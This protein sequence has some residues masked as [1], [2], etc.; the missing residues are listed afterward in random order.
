MADRFRPAGPAEDLPPYYQE[1]CD[2]NI[3][4]C[5]RD[6][7]VERNFDVF[8]RQTRNPQSLNFC[9]DFG[10][11]DAYCAF[12]LDASSYDKLL[13]TPR[14]TYLHTRWINIWMPY[15]QK[16]LIRTLARHF[17]FTP[18]LLGTMCSDPVPPRPT[19]LHRKKSSSTLRS[20]LSNKSNQSGS[21]K[22]RAREANEA[23]LDFESSIGMSE[24]MHSTQL[25]MVQDLT[26]Y[27]LVNDVWHWSTVDWG[28]RFVSMGYNSLHNV[29]TRQRDEHPEDADRAQD[30]PHGKRVW[31]WLLLCEDKTVVSVS[32]DPFPFHN[33][34]LCAEDLRTLFTTR[35]N[36]VNVFRQLTKAP[37]P[38]REAAFTQ[39]P[40]RHRIG[41]SEEETVHRTTD[42]PGLLFY[43]LFEDW[44]STFNL[45][46]RRDKG[47]ANELDRLR[48]EMLV[49]ASLTHV[50]QLHHIGCQLAVLKRVYQSYELI[51]ERVLKKQEATL[52]S[53]KNSR[54][55][56]SGMESLESSQPH[57]PI[58]PEADSLL[59][60]SLSSAAR[61]RFE[62][63]K[64]RINLYALSEI[65]ECLDQKDSLV[66]MNFNLIAIKESFSVERLTWVTLLLAKITI[67]FTPVT[68]MTGY[69]GIEFKNTQFEIGNFWWAFGIIFGVSVGLLF[70]FSLVSGTFEGKIIT[71][72]WS[73]KA[74]DGGWKYLG[75]RVRKG[76]SH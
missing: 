75:K 36:L 23:S 14:P 10:E 13:A 57:G 5:F 72:S 38:L 7:D 35:R 27:Q 29:R 66:M 37:T 32:E 6:F 56:M 52:A 65:Q 69:F 45:I 3:Q 76:K 74:V 70:L 18:R 49:K 15:N 12:D 48:Q 58:M 19:S 4:H 53:L 20:R 25:E 54:I 8:D 39:L 11:H 17:D 63:L 9:L 44:G 47:Y 28:R 55:L 26:H 71:K 62:R 41:N 61:V 50:D 64:D 73:R 67:L 31:Q 34:G 21:I 24:M 60:V 68:L 42:A 16:D 22:A 2:E 1:L 46:S 30:M 40:I 51:I 59:G 43:Y 33:N